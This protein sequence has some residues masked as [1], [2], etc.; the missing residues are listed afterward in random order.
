MA[1]NC[2]A[3]MPHPHFK[4]VSRGVTMISSSP[5]YVESEAKSKELLSAQHNTENTSTK[6]TWN[7][8]C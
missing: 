5:A 7:L 1:T 8:M 3:V 6:L 2:D 4:N